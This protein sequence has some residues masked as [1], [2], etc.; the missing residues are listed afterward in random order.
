M[1]GQ[2]DYSRY[3]PTDVIGDLDSETSEY[4]WGPGLAPPGLESAPPSQ[5]G[6]YKGCEATVD[7]PPNTDVPVSRD[8]RI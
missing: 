1:S 6:R 4:S 5:G 8:L 3:R 7:H 2:S